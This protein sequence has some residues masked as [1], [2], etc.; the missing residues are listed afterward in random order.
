MTHASVTE[1]NMS[2]GGNSSVY[3][4]FTAGAADV[5][6]NFTVNFNGWTGG[7]AGIVNGT[8][9]V[10]TTTCQALTGAT[11]VLP[12]TLAAS[13]ATSIV[14]VTGATA[15]TSG[16]SY[17][18]E[19]NSASAVTNPTSVGQSTVTLTSVTTNDTSK[20][21]IDNI[22]NDQV[23]VSG[24]VSPTFTLGLSGN[25]DS[26][27]SNLSS[28]STVLST[29]V[30]A[31]INTNATSG[32]GIWAIDTQGGLY[33]TSESHRI[34]S[35]ATG[36][37]HTF[38]TGTEQYGIAAATDPTTNYA[39]GGGTTGGGLST[40]VYNE[41][42]SNN[43]PAAGLTTVIHEL[44]DIS[45]VTQSASDYGDIITLVGAGSF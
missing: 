23:T 15:L 39:Y 43:A 5:T 9:T 24:I 34:T 1:T 19:L 31:T 12:G 2:V 33:S 21:A 17:C 32:W 26:F 14:T 42:A 16:S 11:N 41:I 37:L 30:T 7:A 29:G 45:S 13:G 35:V 3:I 36:S 4:S 18:F 10:S 27:A 8:Q 40:T 25:I 38:T 22:S 44:A 20:V 6:S 28:T